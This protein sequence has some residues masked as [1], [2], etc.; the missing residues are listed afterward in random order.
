MSFEKIY[1]TLIK[2]LL[3]SGISLENSDGFEVRSLPL[4]S[5]SIDLKRGFPISRFQ[6]ISFNDEVLIMLWNFQMMSNDVRELHK[7]GIH[8]LDEYMIDSE[9]IYRG[10]KRT[11]KYDIYPRFDDNGY[12]LI[13]RSLISE[14]NIESALYYGSDYSYTTGYSLGK[15]I[16]DNNLSSL[17]EEEIKDSNYGFINLSQNNFNNVSIYNN[18]I[19]NCS[20]YK[21]DN[22]LNFNISLENINLVTELP[23]LVVQYSILLMIMASIS[24]SDVGNINFSIN[25]LYVKNDELNDTSKLL[26]KWN[27]YQRMTRFSKEELNNLKR[28]ILDWKDKFNISS[29]M[30]DEFRF[31]DMILSSTTPEV[32]INPEID[33]IFG[34]DNSVYLRDIKIKGYR[35]FVN[36]R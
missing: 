32:W 27:L 36:F 33:S 10:Y 1:F 35:P 19:T 25:N 30:Y 26:D 15:Y 9:G 16:R 7:R 13:A 23:N 28:F 2:H 24:K 31:I 21:V 22:K 6:D 3:K 34:F 4:Y 14:K 8:K 20:W 11:S 18:G 12:M 29:R 5:F 17:M